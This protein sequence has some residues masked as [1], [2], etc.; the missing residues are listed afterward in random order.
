MIL[1]PSLQSAFWPPTIPRPPT[2]L[3]NSKLS[4]FSNAM[5][6]CRASATMAVQ[7]DPGWVGAHFHA[8]HGVGE[9]FFQASCRAIGM[10]MR[11]VAVAVVMVMVMVMVRFARLKRHFYPL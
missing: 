6:R 11:S 9:R 8:A 2:P 4:G 5:P 10:H 3:D 1:A 7:E